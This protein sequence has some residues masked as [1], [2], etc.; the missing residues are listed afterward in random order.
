LSRGPGRIERTIRELFDAHPDKAFTT[1]DLCLACYSGLNP[2]SRRSF[3]YRAARRFGCP[4]DADMN[5][6]QRKHR[7]AV[8]R[9]ADKVLTGDPNWRS[10]GAFNQGNTLVFHNL[11]SLESVAMGEVLRHHATIDREKSLPKQTQEKLNPPASSKW[12]HE[13][14]AGIERRVHEHVALRDADPSERERLK[15][16]FEARAAEQLQRAEARMMGGSQALPKSSIGHSDNTSPVPSLHVLSSGKSCVPA[17]LIAL[18]TKARALMV[19]N[20]PDA[21]RAGLAEIAETLDALGGATQP[22][23]IAA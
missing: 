8:V 6:V 4:V 12:A 20:D 15:A 16:R 7:V 19:E 3:G 13:D 22:E 2:T 9:A 18:A 11:A 5:L 10:T 23:S 17:T 1:D 21:I 14:K